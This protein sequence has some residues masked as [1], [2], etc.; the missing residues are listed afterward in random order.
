ML[1]RAMVNKNIISI[2]WRHQ[3]GSGGSY[4]VADKTN[5]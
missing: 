2:M 4:I 3:S 1:A 5:I